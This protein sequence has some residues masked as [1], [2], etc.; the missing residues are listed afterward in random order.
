[1][2]CFR[3][4]IDTVGPCASDL[5]LSP[6][7]AVSSCMPANFSDARHI[8]ADDSSEYFSLYYFLG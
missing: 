8:G 5:R 3:A 1:M 6:L 7:Q 4:S 2:E